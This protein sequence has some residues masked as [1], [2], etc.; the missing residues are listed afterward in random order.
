MSSVDFYSVTNGDVK[1]VLDPVWPL[2][3]TAGDQPLDGLFAAD[4]NLP[5]LSSALVQ[6]TSLSTTHC[7]FFVNFFMNM[8]WETLSKALLKSGPTYVHFSHLPRQKSLYG[9]LTGVS[10]MFPLHKFRLKS[11]N[12]L[13]MFWNLFPRLLAWT[14][15]EGLR[16]A[17][18]AC[19]SPDPPSWPSWK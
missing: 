16:W 11:P 8:T 17:W 19:S 3:H 7:P 6:S 1:I 4:N 2:G 5:R 12:H 15:S 18:L 14:P 9:R 13:H 10:D